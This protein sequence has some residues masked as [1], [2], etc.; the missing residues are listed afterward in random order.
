MDMAPGRN[1]WVASR[2]GPAAPRPAMAPCPS[3]RSLDAL[4]GATQAAMMMGMVW[5]LI[6]TTPF[7]WAPP[8][9]VAAGIK[10]SQR[11]PR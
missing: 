9:W 4:Q 11:P 5:P 1:Q 8:L 7:F 3:R 2:M 10:S 6:L